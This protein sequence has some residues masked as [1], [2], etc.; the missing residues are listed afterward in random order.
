MIVTALAKTGCFKVLERETLEEI[1]EELELL[2]AQPK[3]TLKGADFLLTGSITALEMNAS[4][5]GG[6][7]VVIPLPFLGGVGVNVGKSKAHIAIDMRLVQVRGAEVLVAETVEGKS[8][9]WKFGVGGG[10]VFGTVIGGGWFEAF[11]NTPMEEATRDLIYHAV[12]LIVNRVK[13]APPVKSDSPV[14]TVA[15][16]EVSEKP[17][18]NRPSAS[19]PSDGVV[20]RGGDTFK[21][22]KIIWQENFSNCQVIPQGLTVLRGTVECVEF[23]GKKWVATI[24]G[25]A[26]L[27]KS[28][29]DFKPNADWAL[30]F[31]AYLKMGKGS[32][33]KR[34]WLFLERENGPI[35][36]G[37]YSGG[38]FR[39]GDKE[40]P[41]I[42]NAD[43]RIHTIG[44]M[45]RG[46]TFSIFVDG[47]R[48]ATLP[49]DNLL[50]S[51]MKGNLI[52]I[53]FADDIQ[54]G[55]YAFIT[56]IKLSVF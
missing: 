18:V 11:K 29:P 49:A 46:D 24:K 28:I 50:L 39:F 40:L 26:I 52:F 25:E 34:V 32:F 45:K 55:D 43:G 15:Q 33:Q 17:R 7:G 9:R 19:V 31:T 42:Q 10:G 22:G 48:Y 5:V 27:E 54:L 3:A 41:K 30:E 23:G 20:R 16:G 37:Y 44:I 35:S 13:S 53:L 2:G 38:G 47:E 56:D 12:N 8:E 4:G 21:H 1:K 14:E 36:I 6:G 51:R